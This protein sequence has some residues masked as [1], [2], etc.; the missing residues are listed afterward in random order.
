MPLQRALPKGMTW[1]DVLPALLQALRDAA[2]QR[3]VT[4]DAVF[5]QVVIVIGLDFSRQKDK[6]EQA[7]VSASCR[8]SSKDFK[9]SR[10][11]HLDA[12]SSHNCDVNGQRQ[13]SGS[14][15]GQSSYKLGQGRQK[16]RR[17]I[18][19]LVQPRI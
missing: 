7:K 4:I 8:N 5:G 18:L 3:S 15:H 6:L 10:L 17:Y 14:R 13:Q 2:R 19:N 11:M 16:F 9:E 1:K 12:A